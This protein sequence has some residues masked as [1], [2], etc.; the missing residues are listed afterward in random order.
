MA[1]RLLQAAHLGSDLAWQMGHS[2]GKEQ[3]LHSRSLVCVRSGWQTCPDEKDCIDKVSQLNVAG[4][5]AASE[6]LQ[7]RAATYVLKSCISAAVHESL[8]LQRRPGLSAASMPDNAQATLVH[9]NPASTAPSSCRRCCNPSRGV[10]YTGQHMRCCTHLSAITGG[11]KAAEL[12]LMAPRVTS[13][14][15]SRHMRC[16]HMLEM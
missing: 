1:S 12:H 3:L 10:P 7:R 5:L 14:A 15:A 8:S 16:P 6:E 4:T 11:Q 13:R 2:T 9:S